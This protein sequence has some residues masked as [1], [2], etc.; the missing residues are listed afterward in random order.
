MDKIKQIEEQIDDNI[1]IEA[2]YIASL[3]EIRRLTKVVVNLEKIQENLFKIDIEKRQR[4]K[5]DL[6]N[7]IIWA[8][9]HS[10][11]VKTEGIFEHLQAVIDDL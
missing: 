8:V 3:G 6:K 11:V 2:S 7:A 9:T 10:G 5:K 1:D 4:E